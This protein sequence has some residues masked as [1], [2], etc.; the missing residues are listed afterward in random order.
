MTAVATRTLWLMAV[1]LALAGCAR[2]LDPPEALAEARG[3]IDRGEPGEARILLKNLLVRHPQTPQARVLLARIALEAGD[4]K[5]A[6]DELAPVA[7]QSLADAEALFIRWRTDVA[8]GRHRDV[9]VELESPNAIKLDAVQ[10]ARLRA[11]A[12]RAS[13][14]AA[15]AIAP[16]REAL[17][18]APQEALLVVDLAGSLAA[19]GNLSQAERELDAFLQ[20]QPDSADALLARGE[21]RMRKGATGEAL[22]D[23]ERALSKAPAGWPPASRLST[24]ILIGDALLA[25]GAIADA[26]GQLATIEREIPGSLGARLLAA[27]I[28]LLEGRAGEA[29]DTLQQIDDI[30]PGNPRVQ[31]LLVD[32]LLR[33]G[34]LARATEVLARRVKNA[35]DDPLARRLLA[36]LLL[37]QSRPDEVVELLGEFE[38]P[39]GTGDAESDGLLAEARLARRRASATIG[40]LTQRLAAE[41][42]SA[43]LRAELAAAHLSNG[44]PR[45]ALS[46]LRE[47]KVA[48]VTPLA[49]ATEVGAL[50]AIGND[51]ELVLLVQRLAG[52]LQPPLPVLIAAADAAQRGG[53]NDLARQLVD[54]VIAREAGNPEALLRRANLEFLERRYEPARETLKMLQQADPTRADLKLALARVAEAEGDVATARDALVQAVRTAPAALEPSLALAALE[55]RAGAPVA[56]TAAIDALISAA[57]VDGVAA[58][59]AGKLLLDARRYDE[60]LPRFRRAIEQ[61]GEVA[62]YWF[63]LGRAQV[64]LDDRAAAG[65]SF[66][67]AAQLQPDWLE[68]GTLAVR[69]SLAQRDLS[70]ARRTLE[71]L[72]AQLPRHPLPQLLEGALFRAEGRPKQASEAFAQSYATRPTAQAALGDHEARVAGRL[73]RPEQPLLNWLARQPGDVAVRRS[74]ADYF[75]RSGREVES[76]AQFELLLERVPGDVAALNNAAWLLSATDP[77]RAEA[78]ARKAYAIAPQNGA[79]ADTLGWVLLQAGRPAEAVAPL[80]AAV[81]ALPD[82]GSV[83][84][85]YA[86]A[87]ARSGDSGAARSEVARALAM[88][89]QFQERGAAERLAQELAP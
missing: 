48:A 19:V 4:A 30:A 87:L 49:A 88:T 41:P 18:A 3:L 34:N 5:A 17:S 16:L 81:T 54:A 20:R 70:G 44:D 35:P 31:Y 63:N 37:S 83:R 52:E 76:L 33:G 75:L 29:S 59:A 71:A 78:L 85:H 50:R 39:T 74:L 80:A 11:A 60:A 38:S 32:A 28:A 69:L 45:Q 77:A 58:N 82:N 22:S 55:L 26:K 73:P 64:A 57:P 42:E 12:L 14:S 36:R 6:D 53:R 8:M 10:R 47:A 46:V 15:D 66:S 25:T 65:E 21:L 13:G 72:R 1:V 24:R 2:N 68:A 84:Y 62:E 86:L 79:V 61:A 7:R 56:A 9:L 40:A 43:P 89:A 23:L 27:R 67:R 51:R